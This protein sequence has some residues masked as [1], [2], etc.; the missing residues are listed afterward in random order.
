MTEP[1]PPP[2]HTL[3]QLSLSHSTHLQHLLSNF[4][5]TLH[6]HTHRQQQLNTPA[7]ATTLLHALSQWTHKEHQ[8]SQR[9]QSLEQELLGSIHTRDEAVATQYGLEARLTQAL[10]DCQGLSTT[11]ADMRAKQRTAIQTRT[12]LEAELVQLKAQLK[13][14]VPA[15]KVQS[16]LEAAA[17]RVE[18]ICNGATKSKNDLDRAKRE[19]HRL[20]AVVDTIPAL[21]EAQTKE[22]I[23]QRKRSDMIAKEERKRADKLER[24]LIELERSTN[25]LRGMLKSAQEGIGVMKTIARIR[26]ADGGGE[27]GRSIGFDAVAKTIDGISGQVDAR[28]RMKKKMNRHKKN[29][30]LGGMGGHRK[31]KDM[32]ANMVNG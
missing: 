18:G 11:S 28:V 17:Q 5:A 2:P 15:A 16:V 32:F 13:N 19:I 9:I 8:Q 7:R 29:N 14:S 26:N 3:Q 12:A 6:Q 22:E 10:K 25:Q 31:K 30:G 27:G 4:T 20:Q 21:V 24:R 23:R 1:P